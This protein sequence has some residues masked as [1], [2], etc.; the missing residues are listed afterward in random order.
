MRSCVDEHPELRLG[1]AV[2]Y[3]LIAQEVERVF[4]EMVVEGDDGWKRVDYTRLPFVLLQ[5]LREEHARAGALA[6]ENAALRDRLEGV[7]RRLAA[8]ESPR[9]SRRADIG[10]L[11]ALPVALIGGLVLLRRRR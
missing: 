3:S 5:G 2:T 11:W 10:L 8:L 9:S 4:P 1:E 6:A 7:E